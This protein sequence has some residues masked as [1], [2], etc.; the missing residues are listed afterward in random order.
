[1]VSGDMQHQECEAMAS[2]SIYH[3]RMLVWFC[4]IYL[5]LTFPAQLGQYPTSLDRSGSGIIGRM[6]LAEFTRRRLVNC[7]WREFIYLTTSDTI[8]RSTY[9]LSIPPY[10]ACSHRVKSS[11]LR[12]VRC[13]RYTPDFCIISFRSFRVSILVIIPH[14]LSYGQAP[15]QRLPVLVQS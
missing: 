12:W 15:T 14:Q 6:V 1:M 5:L 9:T 10:L 7:V 2:D 8:L 3:P 11:L 4:I 13:F